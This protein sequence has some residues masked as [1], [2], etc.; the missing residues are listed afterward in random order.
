MFELVHPYKFPKNGVFHS[1]VFSRNGEETLCPAS[2]NF[3]FE[4]SVVTVDPG[5]KPDQ[6]YARR[7]DMQKYVTRIK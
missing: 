4:L 3:F 7:R 2:R 6:K 5:S 1:V